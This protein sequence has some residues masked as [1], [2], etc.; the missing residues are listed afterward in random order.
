MNKKIIV[1]GGGTFSHIRSHLSLAVPAFGQTAVKISELCHSRFANME[2]ELAL[3]RMADPRHAL[4]TITRELTTNQDI[5]WYID[6]LITLNTTKVIFFSAGMCDFDGEVLDYTQNIF[7]LGTVSGKYE[8]RLSSAEEYN[9]RLTTTE[10]IISK[11]RKQRKDIFLVGFKTTCG[12]SK[13]EQFQKGLNLLKSASCNLVVVNDVKTRQ[14]AIIT[15]EEAVYGEDLS[16][17]ELL[18]ELVD[19]VYWRTHLSFTR[20]TVVDGKPVAWTEV[21]DKF[22][23][24]TKVVEYCIAQGAYKPFNGATVGHFAAK[25]SDNTF[26]TSIRKTNFNDIEKTGMVLVKTDGPDNVISYGA[27]PSVGGQSQRMI[28]NKYEDVDSIVHFHC[29]LKT[30][31]ID[32]IPVISQR[33]VEC[34][35]HTCGEHTANGLKK[36]DE[37]YCVMLDK[38]GPNIVF[39]H[40]VEPQKVI[41]FIEANF[42]LSGTTAGFKEV[43]LFDSKFSKSPSMHINTTLND[44]Q[45]L[46]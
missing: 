42:D 10:K 22:P 33:E 41:N 18:K 37:I 12:D 11:I 26:Y 23:A 32:D 7:G 38:H 36:F 19:M 29:P 34:G 39:H 2:I 5:K 15:P 9:I 40:S 4:S 16:R 25:I 43:I 8:K 20:S 1:L 46:I 31:H 13:E 35:S 3:T 44:L 28:F 14:N 21:K 45:T 17:D 30:D 27:K 6:E 24:L